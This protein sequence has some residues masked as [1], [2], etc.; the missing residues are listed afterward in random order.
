MAISLTEED[1]GSPVEV[2]EFV[3]PPDTHGVSPHSRSANL[4]GDKEDVVELGCFDRFSVD[5]L[6][7]TSHRQAGADETGQRR[8]DLN[9]ASAT[10]VGSGLGVGAVVSGG[11]RGG[12]SRRFL[13]VT[14]AAER[15]AEQDEGDEGPNALK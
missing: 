13:V 2:V 12:D 5:E 15:D 14:A 4:C 10:G 6:S 11:R 8:R 1:L 9:T 3:S 7:A